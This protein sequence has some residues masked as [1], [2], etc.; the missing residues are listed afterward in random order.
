MSEINGFDANEGILSKEN[1]KF[2]DRSGKQI[3]GDLVI[4]NRQIVFMKKDQ[5]LHSFAL[6]TIRG[7][8]AESAGQIGAYFSIDLDSLEGLTT[9]RYKGSVVQ[10]N[11]ILGLVES[12]TASGGTVPP[13]DLATIPMSYARVSSKSS[14]DALCQG[15]LCCMWIFVGLIFRIMLM[16]A[17]IVPG[18]ELIPGGY[19][20]LVIVVTYW[21]VGIKGK[22]AWLCYGVECGSDKAETVGV[23]TRRGYTTPPST[24][25]IVPILVKEREMTAPLKC[26]LCG[27]EFSYKKE[28]VTLNTV[29]C[30]N[31]LEYFSIE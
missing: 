25:E 13:T 26:P 2:I 22:K 31:C 16:G 20:L 19:I 30:Q 28:D 27:S 3:T 17:T 15:A 5:I 24:K 11:R 18:A 14:F 21:W 1:V 10:A 4:T 29:L 23:G 6:E 8:R 12:V 9:T 7:A